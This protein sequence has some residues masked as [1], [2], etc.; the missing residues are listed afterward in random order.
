MLLKNKN[1]KKIFFLLKFKMNRQIQRK[2]I[3]IIVEIKKE[4]PEYNIKNITNSILPYNFETY[5]I[6]SLTEEIMYIVG[7]NEKTNW[8]FDMA[9]VDLSKK[10]III[11]SGQS[12]TVENLFTFTL[13][14]K[15]VE[16]S[17]KTGLDR[18]IEEEEKKICSICCEKYKDSRQCTKCLE[19]FCIYC[20]I[21]LILTGF[22]K[23]TF[24]MTCP[25]CM[26]D[27]TI[28]ENKEPSIEAIQDFIIQ[29]KNRI[30]TEKLK[31]NLTKKNQ[32]NL[33]NELQELYSEY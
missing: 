10:Y 24:N 32:I 11:F 1:E 17:S 18:I 2:I 25:F 28:I 8:L 7:R 27:H 20:Q 30:N 15:F 3:E 14:K 26:Y 33:L 21:K 16:R 23:K 9:M 6:K 19:R 13:K 22:T 4:H 29:M 12:S 5:M 31:G